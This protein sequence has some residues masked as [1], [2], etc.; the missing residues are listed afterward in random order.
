MQELLRTVV[1][2]QKTQ[3]EYMQR[4]QEVD[5]ENRF[6]VIRN[7]PKITADNNGA[8]LLEVHEL[9]TGSPTSESTKRQGM[10][11]DV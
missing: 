2:V 9:R 11:D 7:I 10:D 8:D 5:R 3:A 4:R 1:G 6:K